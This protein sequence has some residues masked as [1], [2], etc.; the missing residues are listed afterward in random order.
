MATKHDNKASSG[1]LAKN[2]QHEYAKRTDDVNDAVSDFR[3]EVRDAAENLREEYDRRVDEVREQVDESIDGGRKSVADHPFL[4]VGV[5]L[6]VGI[7][8]G[9]LIRRKSNA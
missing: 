8:A 6:A 7:L 2:M 3:V 1:E 9:L 4:A 5:A